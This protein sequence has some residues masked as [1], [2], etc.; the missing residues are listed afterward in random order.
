MASTT[1]N[2]NTIFDDESKVWSVP[3]VNKKQKDHT[4]WFFDH[5]DDTYVELEPRRWDKGPKPKVKWDNKDNDLLKCLQ[6]D[7]FQSGDTMPGLCSISSFED[8]AWEFPKDSGLDGLDEF[9]CSTG[10]SFFDDQALDWAKAKLFD[11]LKATS[12]EYGNNVS[13]TIDQEVEPFVDGFD[14]GISAIKSSATSQ[15]QQSLVPVEIEFGYRE[16]IAIMLAPTKK[17][18]V[19]TEPLDVWPDDEVDIPVPILIQVPAQELDRRNVVMQQ[20]MK[21]QEQLNADEMER[22]AGVQLLRELWITSYKKK[23]TKSLSQDQRTITL[24]W[25]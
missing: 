5:F 3:G 8:P 14:D 25:I 6:K 2:V 13:N 21:S 23:K 19:H 17:F 4:H 18:I 20:R 10:T 11:P 12:T 22:L 7:K 24:V 16:K 15:V 1:S 9:S